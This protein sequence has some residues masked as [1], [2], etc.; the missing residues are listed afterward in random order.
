[1]TETVAFVAEAGHE[2]FAERSIGKDGDGWKA[3]HLLVFDE[4][5]PK[6]PVVSRRIDPG[7]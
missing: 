1:V 6:R 3:R 5:A 7:E 2:H 4:S